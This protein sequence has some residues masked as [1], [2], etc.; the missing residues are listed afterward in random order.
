MIEEN[1]SPIRI[2]YYCLEK[3]QKVFC[4]KLSQTYNVRTIDCENFLLKL[5]QL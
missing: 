1:L 3:D 5:Y 4:T 2:F